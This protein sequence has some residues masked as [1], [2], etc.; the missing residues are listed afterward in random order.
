MVKAAVTGLNGRWTVRQEGGSPTLSD[1][2]CK[3]HFP[4][5]LMTCGP[6]HDGQQFMQIHAAEYW[7][8]HACMGTWPSRQVF[9]TLSWATLDGEGGIGRKLVGCLQ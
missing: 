9:V 1:G 4:N 3:K 2:V 8:N 6:K 7:P 5:L